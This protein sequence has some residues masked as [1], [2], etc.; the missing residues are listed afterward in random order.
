[1]FAGLVTEG[2]VSYANSTD[3]DEE[4]STTATVAPEK[5][6]PATPAVPRA[7]AHS[8]P[9]SLLPEADEDEDDEDD[10]DDGR[11]L[12]SAR[13][14]AAASIFGDVDVDDLRTTIAT[15][16]AVAQDLTLFRSK[17]FKALRE[18]IGPLAQAMTGEA[19]GGGGGGKRG[20]RRGGGAASG[21]KLDGLSPLERY[22]QMDRD[23]LNHRVLRAERLARLE[24][25]QQP[26]NA[27]LLLTNSGGDDPSAS[28]N[29]AQS[30]SLVPFQAKAG[31]RGGRG[32][33]A[34]AIPDGPAL[35]FGTADDGAAAAE[36]ALLEAAPAT[37][38]LAR[39]CYI[40]K[41]PYRELHAF[42]AQLC[43][44]C[45]E[46]NWIKRTEKCNLYGRVAL[47]TGARVKIGFR[48]AL[49]LLRCGCEVIATTRFPIDSVRRFAAE[50]DH[51]RWQHR[52]HIIGADLRDLKGLEALCDALPRLVRRLDIIINNACQTVRRPPQYYQ[53]L[54]VAEVAQPEE[55]AYVRRWTAAHVAIRALAG[56]A[57]APALDLSDASAAMSG[58]G[59]GVVVAE[60]SAGGRTG[61]GILPGMTLPVSAVPGQS[62]MLSQLA[63]VPGDDVRDDA[64]F[65]QG[66]TDGN[67][68]LGQQLDLRAKNS[69]MLKLEEVST[70]EMAEVLAINALAP[71]VIN[72]RLRAFMQL[73]GAPTPP[74]LPPTDAADEQPPTEHSLK[75]IVNVSAM[76]GRFYKFKQPTHP[77]TNMAK[78]ALNMMTRTSAAD[79]A[80]GQIYMTAVDTGWINDEKPAAQAAADAQTHNFQTP[81]DEI[82]AAARVLD[83][84]IAP[85]RRLAAG[86][87][88][89]PE[90]GVFLKDYA[91]CEW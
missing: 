20:G 70:P 88:P 24:E 11:M 34:G 73:S 50:E 27:A 71:A 9:A 64:A 77:H 19:V 60:N 48:I 25:L 84:I 57:E 21:T 85:L 52:L 6:A 83:P 46:F 31:A 28:L 45:A 17:P 63:I 90:Y 66:R 37:L 54:L 22:K 91:M 49:K 4:V 79:Y 8:Q 41:R 74:P 33:S 62:A 5:A 81:I 87:D 53:P 26:G 51:P 65:P 29:A 58:D 35:A 68:D 10:E 86:E 12:P 43:M 1:M 72:G 18:A 2:D 32:I 55:A 80:K 82:D 78:A 7:P 69:W 40:C 13:Q 59:I 16:K 89:R 61:E 42:Y 76:E 15:L 14:G 56:A 39:S 23:A 30:A 3:A 38:H 44:G 47:V 75:F 36:A 67:S